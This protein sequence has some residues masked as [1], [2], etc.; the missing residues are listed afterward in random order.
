MEY[1]FLLNTFTATL[2]VVNP[3][4]NLPAFLPLSRGCDVKECRKLAFNAVFTMW[5]ALTF[6]AIAGQAVLNGL[7][8]SLS[9]LQIGG[10][11]LLLTIG[12]KMASGG[13]ISG[14]NVSLENRRGN[15]IVPIGIPVLAGPGAI[16]VVLMHAHQ[17][18]GAFNAALIAIPLAAIAIICFITLTFG[19]KIAAILGDSGVNVI[20]R[21]MGLLIT[22]IAA[23]LVLDGLAQ[24]LG[25][26]L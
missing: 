24:G 14:D 5:I 19:Q 10:G 16:T 2:A 6:I 12:L 17:A 20:T 26:V 18:G 11:I 21:I 1:L 9:A 22:T 8:L 4:G 3:P 15:A 7:G 13:D 25:G 23:Q